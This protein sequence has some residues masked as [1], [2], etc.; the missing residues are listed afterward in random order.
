MSARLWD[1]CELQP[2]ERSVPVLEGFCLG[3]KWGLRGAHARKK[4][5]TPVLIIWGHGRH[6]Q[7]PPNPY[8]S[9]VCADHTQYERD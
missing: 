4:Y 9:R 8:C 5:K 2:S 6:S 3:L 7:H 1:V